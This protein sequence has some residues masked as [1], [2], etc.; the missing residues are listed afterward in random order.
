MPRSAESRRC[1]PAGRG[2]AQLA[3]LP[4]LAV[5][6]V[7]LDSIQPWPLQ[8]FW[9]L[10]EWLACLHEP[11]PLQALRPTQ[12]TLASSARALVVPAAPAANSAAAAAA[13]TTPEVLRMAV[14]MK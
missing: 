5:H 9:P 6:S 2:V 8:A 13:T 1:R 3:I 10:Q 11:W 14:I 12:C 7:L 4:P